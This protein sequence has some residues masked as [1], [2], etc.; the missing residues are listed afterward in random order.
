M[1]RSSREALVKGLTD[2]D[3]FVSEL[4]LNST[5]QNRANE[6]YRDAAQEGTI[7][8]GRGVEMVAAACVVLAARESDTILAAADVA[9]VAAEHIMEKTIHRTTKDVRNKLDL[10][11]VLE[12][13][14][15]FVGP[16][17]DA[18]NASEHD[19]ELAET[20]IDITMDDGV[21]SGKKASAIAGSAYYVVSVLP[22]GEGNFTQSNVASAAD[23]STVTIRN[24]YRDFE[25]VAADQLEDK[26]DA[27][28]HRSTP[29]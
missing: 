11:F 15:K 29:P 12:D 21:A 19:R 7:L 26:F 22:Q 6:I 10:G 5:I 9:D 20:I 28:K 14:H 16:I 2:I 17:G 1:D 24:T 13:P 18:V 27:S 8:S 3:T 25:E 4:R 23:I